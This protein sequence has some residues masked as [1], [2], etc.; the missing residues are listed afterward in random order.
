MIVLEDRRRLLLTLSLGLLQLLLLSTQQA[1]GFVPLPTTIPCSANSRS[2]VGSTRV[3]TGSSLAAVSE[4]K[5]QQQGPLENMQVAIAGAGPTGLLLAHLLLQ[6]GARVALYESRADPR[7]IAASTSS[8]KSGFAYAL[9]LGIRGRSAIRA[10]DESLWQAV[11]QKGNECDR[12]RLHIGPFRVQLRAGNTN[13]KRTFFRRRRNNNNPKQQPEPSLLL[14]QTDLCGSL[15]EELEQRYSSSSQLQMFF[16]SRILECDLAKQRITI[17]RNK[18]VTIVQAYDLLV[19]CD[20]VNSIVRS[21]MKKATDT[22]F[23]ADKQTLPGEFKVARLESIPPKLDPT[24]VALLIPK[25]GTT[26][27]FLEPTI[28]GSCCIL[29]AGREGDAILSSPT[30]S[31][32]TEQTSSNNKTRALAETIAA[33]FPL[34]EGAD[35]DHV[36]DQ[37]LAQ[38]PG[39]ASSVTCNT[40]HYRSSVALAGDAAHATGGVSGQGVNSALLDAV[41]LRDC[42][43]EYYTTSSSQNRND[44]ALQSALEAYSKR[45]VPEG[46]ALYDLSFGPKPRGLKKLLFLAKGFRDTV[47]QGRWGIGKPPLQTLLTTSMEPFSSIR[48]RMDYYYDTPFPDDDYFDSA[49]SSVYDDASNTNSN[50]EAEKTNATERPPQVRQ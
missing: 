22:A 1:V 50:N 11:R 15:L 17:D 28:E 5:Q 46:K 32:S 2:P 33:S 6:K 10:V 4:D 13:K 39:S 26:T 37:L 24:S 20:G 40:Y 35:L 44:Q 34:L 12:F 23:T 19:G 38:K 27:A 36:A 21:A 47:F 41:A 43:L 48:R 49:I 9:G 16:S 29:F 7:R 30:I 18:N 3:S 45:Q 25:T 42:L 31:T 8:S 14:F